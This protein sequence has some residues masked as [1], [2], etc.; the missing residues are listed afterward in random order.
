MSPSSGPRFRPI[1]AGFGAIVALLTFGMPA[2][3]EQVAY[4]FTGV[5]SGTVDSS[6]W[7]GAF[8][9]VFTADTSNITSGSGEVFQRDISGTFSE[10]SYTAT[11]NADNTV[12]VNNDPSFPR[13]GFFNST[14]DNGGAI[15]NGSLTSYMLDTSFGP[16]TGTGS[17][18]LPTFN[19][20]G[21]GFDTTGGQTIELL[22]MTSLTF[23]ASV[24]EP[25]SLVLV[26]TGLAAGIGVYLRRRGTAGR[27][28]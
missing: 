21:H 19:S 22:T 4:T 8:T 11:L 7:S 12:V 24:P 23:T 27:V 1:L 3:A 9:F 10:G 2:H 5:G 28:R 6:T 26:A 14:F 18:L 20:D 17:N 15:Q 16:I 13:I 25:S